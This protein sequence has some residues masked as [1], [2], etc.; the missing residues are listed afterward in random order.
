VSTHNSTS[1]TRAARGLGPAD[2]VLREVIESSRTIVSRDG[3]AGL[4]MRRLC[5]VAGFTTGTLMHHFPD[6][7]S[8]VAAFA[9]GF[10]TD[11]IERVGRALDRAEASSAPHAGLTAIT[12]LSIP[13]PGRGRE[14]WPVWMEMWMNSNREPVI[15]EILQRA[16]GNWEALLEAGLDQSVSRGV[17]S[18]AIDAA[19]EAKLLGRVIDGVGLWAWRSDDWDACVEHLLRHFI[20]LGVGRDVADRVRDEHVG[21]AL[22]VWS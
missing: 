17:L 13:P 11:W 5:E 2:E 15:A 6:K 16:A 20:H 14:E 22:I 10:M 12:A 4:T 8:V 21:E 3:F 9:E 18:P 19:R 1:K 7:R